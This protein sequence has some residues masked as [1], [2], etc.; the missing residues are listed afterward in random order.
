MILILSVI[1]FVFI[2]A[3]YI[4]FYIFANSYFDKKFS[5]I[6]PRHCPCCGNFKYSPSHDKLLNPKRPELKPRYEPEKENFP[7]LK[8][9]SS[10]VS[11]LSHD[12]LNLK[13]YFHENKSSLNYII[14]MHGHTDS[15]KAMSPYAMHFADT[16]WNVIVPGQRGHG[17]SEGKFIDMGAYARFDVIDWINFILTK[18]S[19]AKIVL[20]GSSMGAATVMMATGL[21]LPQNVKCC[22]EDCGFTSVYHQILHYMKLKKIPSFLGAPFIHFICKTKYG[23]NPKQVSAV[24]AVAHS[25]TPTLFIHGTKDNY[26]PYYMMEQLYNAASCPKQKFIVEDAGHTVNIYKNPQAYWNCVDKFIS[27]HC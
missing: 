22:I 26:V 5:A 18:N 4:A 1:L 6:K 11:I 13:A 3:L 23:Y 9:C 27:E 17:W 15:P 19:Q 21:N 7:S 25:K 20:F 10:V 16:G 8:N 24:K 14:L 2:S 12:K